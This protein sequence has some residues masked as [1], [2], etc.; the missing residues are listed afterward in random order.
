MFRPVTSGHV[1]HGADQG[2]TPDVKVLV[3]YQTTASGIRAKTSPIK[4]EQPASSPPIHTV[5]AKVL[6]PRFSLETNLTPT[7]VLQSFSARVGGSK[8]SRR[9]DDSLIDVLD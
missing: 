6:V 3:S 9:C 2:E 4:N 7:G 8:Y 5:H 1:P